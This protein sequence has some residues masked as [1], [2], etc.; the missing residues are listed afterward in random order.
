[1]EIVPKS[2][3]MPGSISGHKSTLIFKNIFP[4]IL[5]TFKIKNLATHNCVKEWDKV[6]PQGWGREALG[7]VRVGDAKFV[8]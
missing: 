5:V 4:K 7:R 6:S 8:R 1:M 3:V 2:H